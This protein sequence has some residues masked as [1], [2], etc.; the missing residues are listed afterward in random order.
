MDART[1]LVPFTH[2]YF[3]QCFREMELK[4]VVIMYISRFILNIFIAYLQVSLI[5][6][7]TV[8]TFITSRNINKKDV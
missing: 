1:S 5:F 4:T 3:F 7:T 8:S 6:Q 2:D